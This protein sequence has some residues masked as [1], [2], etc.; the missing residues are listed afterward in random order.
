MNTS[1]NIAA[2]RAISN[3]SVIGSGLM[4]AGIAQVGAQTGHNVVIFD[5]NEVALG[6]AQKSIENSLKRV[7]KKMEPQKADQ[8]ITQTLGYV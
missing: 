4:G 6:K 3:F 8:F 1:L 5:I 2:K 7:A